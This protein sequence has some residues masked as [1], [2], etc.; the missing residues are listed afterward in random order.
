MAT[1]TKIKL[2]PS[3]LPYLAS[4]LVFVVLAFIF[5]VNTL[6]GILVALALTA[7]SYFLFRK[8]KLFPDQKVSYEEEIPFEQLEVEEIIKEGKAYLDQLD[9]ANQ[10]IQDSGVSWS[11]SE[12]IVLSNNI[13]KK[14]EEDPSQRGKIRKFISYYLPTLKKLLDYYAS[15]EKQPLSTPNVEESKNKIAAMLKTV[16]Q[17]FKQQLDSLYDKDALDISSDIKVMESLMEKE[18]FES[19]KEK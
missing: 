9:Q 10:Q 19:L 18:G 2:I 7:G 6:W 11:I 13:L 12:I 3:N 5:P 16:I 15:L 8:L 4:A 17:G 1:R 14:V